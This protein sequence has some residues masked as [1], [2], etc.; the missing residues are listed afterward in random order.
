MVFPTLH[1][2]I[3]A[4]GACLLNSNHLR[5]NSE[6]VENIISEHW[7]TLPATSKTPN[8]KHTSGNKGPDKHQGWTQKGEGGT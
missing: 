2:S 1:P 8:T 3:P 7:K 4:F 5:G 6:T